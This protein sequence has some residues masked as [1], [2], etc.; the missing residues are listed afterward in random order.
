MEAYQ[1]VGP[2]MYQAQQASGAAGD[3]QSAAGGE[4]GP[5]DEGTPPESPDDVVEGEIV[6]EGE[7]S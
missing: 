5:A 2:A 1:K 4:A 6:D 7:A 3:E